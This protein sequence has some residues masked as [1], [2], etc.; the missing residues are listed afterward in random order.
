VKESSF[1][2]NPKV[3]FFVTENIAIGGQ[4][5]YTSAT[6]DVWNGFD[7]VE[8]K[9]NMFAV[10]AFGRY[11]FTP[12]N[13]FSLFAELGVDYATGTTEVDGTETGDVSGFGIGIAPGIS[14]FIGSNWALEASVG[15]LGYSTVDFGGDD[16]TNSFDLNLNLSNINFGVVYKF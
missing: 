1:T 7:L 2:I 6:A 5:G 8:E 11:Y 14:Y 9:S 3:G 16:N 13:D 12:A 10:G 4:V 15:L